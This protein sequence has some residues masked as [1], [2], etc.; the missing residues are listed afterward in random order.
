MKTRMLVPLTLLAMGLL[1][2]CPGAGQEGTVVLEAGRVLDGGGGVLEARDVVVRDGQI[3]EILPAGEGRGDVRYDLSDRTLLPGLVDTHV[4]IHW[5]FD[6]ATGRTHSGEV[7]ETPEEAVLY[8]AENAWKTLMG[9]V[10]TVQSLGSP[11]DVPLRDF[12]E[13]GAIPGPRILTSISAVSARTGGPAEI[14]RHVDEMADRGADAIKIFASASIRDGGPPTLS[15]EQLDAACGQ[16]RARGL[17][18][19]VHAYDPVITRR[20]VQAGCTTVEHGALLDRASL[21]LMAENGVYFDPNIDLV[22]RNYFENSERFV[23]VGNYSEAGFAEMRKVLPVALE[24]FREALTVPGLKTVFGTDAV[25]G[26]HGRNYQELVYRIE[27]G[28]QDPMA[29]IVSA[30]SLAA[31]SLG[32]EDRIGSVVPGMEADLIALDGDPLQDPGALGRVVFVMKGGTVYKHRP[33]GP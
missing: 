29:A 26:A 33:A 24:I 17:R 19:L 6:R 22:L 27:E 5:H 32:L 31:E 7:E 11:T 3:V 20:L 30:T 28:G 23:G 13:A 25:A 16:A 18:T 2:P 1:S 21:E 4:H 15:Q 9:G 10:T 8:A 14:R 12:V